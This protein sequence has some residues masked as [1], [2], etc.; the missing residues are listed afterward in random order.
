MSHCD[1]YLYFLIQPHTTP[2]QFGFQ[3]SKAQKSSL[4][5]APVSIQESGAAVPV[6]GDGVHGEPVGGEG[7]SS[8]SSVSAAEPVRGKL[9]LQRD[10]LV[11][12]MV[13]R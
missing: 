2:C 13:F 4:H 12:S 1:F 11:F 3:N 6:W 8:R 7:L 10:R 9:L 5:V